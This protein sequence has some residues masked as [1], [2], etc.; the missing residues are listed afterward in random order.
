MNE[1]NN[2]SFSKFYFAI[3]LAFCKAFIPILANLAVS[4]TGA[5]SG[6]RTAAAGVMSPNHPKAVF[7]R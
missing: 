4:K 5:S 2:F 1:I 6:A 3:C 7:Y